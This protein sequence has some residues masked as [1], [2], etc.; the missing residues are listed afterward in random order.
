MI[1]VCLPRFAAYSSLTL[2][3][4]VALFLQL[5][6]ALIIT[7]VTVTTADPVFKLNLGKVIALIGV[8]VQLACFGLFA[9]IAMRFNFTSR[10]FVSEFLLRVDRGGRDKYVVIDGGRRKLKLNWQA[11]LRVV[12]VVTLL[13]LVRTVYRA[14][15]FAMGSKGYLEEHE[16]P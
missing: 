16:W 15:D 13:I 5:V 3:L 11:L 2:T 6:G 4:P 1:S 8:G 12:N 7:S 9:I 10:R 14:V